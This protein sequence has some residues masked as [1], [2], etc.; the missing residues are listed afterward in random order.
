MQLFSRKKTLIALSLGALTALGACGDDVTVP[1]APEAPVV[2]S[3]TPPNATMNIG[4]SLNFAVQI[5]GGSKT[6]PPTLTSCTSSN[7]AVAT[8]AVQTGACRV[9][10]VSSGNVTVTALA[11]TGGAAAA[12]I[13]V[14]PAAAAIGNLTTSPTSATLGVGQ[15]LTIVPN[16]TKPTA[17]V[18]VVY[19]YSTSSSAIAGVNPTTGVVTAVAPGTATITVT[20]SGSGA[21]FTTTQ[22]TAGVTINV[23]AAP[24]SLTGLTV[25]PT[26]IDMAVGTTRQISAVVTAAPGITVPTPTFSSNATS[27]AQVTSSG[28]VTAVSPGN[29][30]ITVTATSA[31]TATLAA[32]TLTQLVTITVS[33][34]ANVTIQSIIQG[35]YKT[36]DIDS[37]YTGWNTTPLLGSGP[38]GPLSGGAA[39]GSIAGIRVAANAQVDQSVDVTNTRDQIQVVLNLQ[40][41]SQ[42][43]DSV[44][45]YVDPA[46][47]GRRAAAR[48]T[49]SQAPSGSTEVRLYLLTDDFTLNSATGVGDV[50]FPNGLK[51]ISASVWTTLPSGS[52]AGSCPVAITANNTCEL[53]NASAARQNINFN[54]IDGFALTM[55]KPA[56]TALDAA[57]RSWWGGPTVS[58]IGQPTGITSFQA[59]PV[60]YTPGRTIIQLT[61]GF[62][63]CLGF[64]A[65]SGVPVGVTKTAL[66][67]TFTAGTAAPAGSTASHIA[68]GGLVG[69]YDLSDN[70]RFEDYPH[71]VASLDNSQNPGPRTIYGYNP[72]LGSDPFGGPRPTL[73]RNSPSATAPSALRVDYQAPVLTLTVSHPNGERWVNDPYAF[74]GTSSYFPYTASDGA[75]A[76]GLMATR[77]TI[78]RAASANPCAGGQTFSDIGG[79]TATVAQ[80]PAAVMPPNREHP[81]DFTNNA[82]VAQATETDRLGNRG[83]IGNLFTAAAGTTP[84]V[85]A[86]PVF[87]IDNTAPEVQVAWDGAG[88]IPDMP[89]HYLATGDSIFQP[90]GVAAATPQAQAPA[91]NLT[92]FNFGV[93]YRDTRSGFNIANH[94]TRTVT[95]WAPNATPLTSN[96][97]VLSTIS[98]R[99]MNFTGGVGNP[100]ESQDPTYRRDSVTIYGRGPLA[101]H[102]GGLSLTASALVPVG[103]YQY[104]L[105]LVDR[106]QNTTDF[107]SNPAT[108]QRAVIDRTSPQIT[109]TTIPAVWG[110]SGT[111]TA[112]AQSFGPTGTDD[113]EAFDTDLFLRYPAFDFSGDGSIGSLVSSNAA[114]VKFRRERG[115]LQGFAN[116]QNPWDVF[117]T[118]LLSTPFGPGAALS[119]AGMLMPIPSIRG[120]EPV[121]PTDAPIAWTLAT[122][123]FGGFKP[124]LVGLYAYDVRASHRGPTTT[125]ALFTAPYTTAVDLP[126]NNLGHTNTFPGFEAAYTEP[127]FAGNVSNGSRWDVKDLN[128][129]T[130]TADLLITWSVFSQSGSQVQVRATTGTVVTQPPFPTVNLFKWEADVHH[131]GTGVVGG[132]AL[133]TTLVDSAAGNWVYIATMTSAGAPANPS[134]FDQGST[135]FWTYT[136]TFADHNIGAVTQGGTTGGCYRAVGADISGDG[137]VTRSFGVGCPAEVAVAAGTNPTVT[138]RIYGNGTGTISNT[139]VSPITLT[140]SS[141]GNFVTRNS[142]NV[143]NGALVTFT[144]TPTGGSTLQQAPT[145][146]TLV[147]APVF[148]TAGVVTCT[149]PIGFGPRTIT[150][151]FELP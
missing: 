33:P 102:T 2:V 34:T 105:S 53:Q 146:C 83:L 67:Y 22:L 141:S 128:T 30:Q 68:C 129:L 1:V 106:A 3:I 61:A 100:V 38:T 147:G 116:F 121:D 21:G 112:I 88:P 104:Q 109:G 11:S 149:I 97:A 93:R 19:A 40:T 20:A 32:T 65:A 31:G 27:V 142:G 117:T 89:N 79:L 71:V 143:A 92:D 58:D 35:P 45:V 85:A 144:I 69:A 13:N 111:A 139:V 48:Q 80:I 43:V 63:R 77:N 6:T 23:T 72:T 56:N 113:V 25:Q 50:H 55:T 150:A 125:P 52:T 41:N 16:V 17:A 145:G 81:C 114:R 59:W 44:V 64:N 42:R 78:F 137:I 29:A 4:E 15:T 115:G 14:A 140:K 90:A 136:M 103:Y 54:N 133:P 101:N 151:I 130:A 107:A 135:R 46:A 91:A 18:V 9:T 47:T 28:L 123:P 10:A 12:S 36:T 62:G 74:N 26:N 49:F 132:G 120:I 138:Q 51:A 37:S 127:L 126:F 24:P 82:Y 96:V 75:P 70:F 8:A 98:T 122:N 99:T 39:L 84:A 94:G 73:F 108:R 66:P 110:A 119:N 148:P 131:T 87:G 118:T 134:L 60:I 86:S 57:A 5:T 7:T 95:R 76:V 124:N